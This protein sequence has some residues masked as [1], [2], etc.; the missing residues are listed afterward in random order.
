MPF[1]IDDLIIFGVPALLALGTAKVARGPSDG[2][3]GPPPASYAPQPYAYGGMPAYPMPQQPYAAE[4]Y[5]PEPAYG[6]GYLA[7]NEVTLT[8][9]GGHF[10]ANVGYGDNVMNML[11]DT[12]ASTCCVGDEVWRW[13]KSLGIR[14]TGRGRATLAGGAVATTERF[15]FPYLT[16]IGSDNQSFLTVQDVEAQY[17]PGASGLLGMSFLEKCHVESNGNQMILRG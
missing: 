7:Q 3:A 6:Y 16:V 2:A 10:Y 17:L 9:H 15:T 14:S 11:V 12:G 1:L 4:A 8:K 13:L 5:S